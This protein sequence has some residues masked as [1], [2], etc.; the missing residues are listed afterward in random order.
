MQWLQT[1]LRRLVKTARLAELNASLLKG[2]PALIG[3]CQVH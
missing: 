1:G 3:R 2:D